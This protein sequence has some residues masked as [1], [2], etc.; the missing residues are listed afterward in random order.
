MTLEYWHI[1]SMKSTVLIGAIIL[2]IKFLHTGL[3]FILLI[4]LITIVEKRMCDLEREAATIVF[5]DATIQ[6]HS[7]EEISPRK[8]NDDQIL[9]HF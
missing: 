4:I 8:V 6:H 3:I 2:L 1:M 9:I 7:V 5:N